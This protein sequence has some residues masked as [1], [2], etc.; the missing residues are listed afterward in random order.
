M[1]PIDKS[2]LARSESD[3]EHL[4]FSHPSFIQQHPHLLANIK[5]KSPGVRNN[6]NT[7][8]NIPTRELNVLLGEIRQLREKQRAMETKM[9]H[10]VKY[11]SLYR[12]TSYFVTSISYLFIVCDMRIVGTDR[13]VF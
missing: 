3:Q 10:L 13:R 8:M 2:S 4:E 11:A 9:T 5:R 12:S 7:S 6:E 1:T